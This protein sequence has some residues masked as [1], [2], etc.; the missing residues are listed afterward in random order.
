MKMRGVDEAKDEQIKGDAG[1][2]AQLSRKSLT[3]LDNQKA[4]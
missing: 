1:R 4:K 2:R 3:T